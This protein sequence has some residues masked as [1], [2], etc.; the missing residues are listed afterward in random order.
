[1]LMGYFY[2][3]MTDCIFRQLSKENNEKY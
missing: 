1:V 2:D 3:I